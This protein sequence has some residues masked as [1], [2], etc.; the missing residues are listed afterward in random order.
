M[1]YKYFYTTQ[2]SKCFACEIIAA[3]VSKERYVL[4][5]MFINSY[6]TL[7]NK[8]AFQVLFIFSRHS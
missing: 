4:I 1:M 3:F 2:Q 5:L 7:L 8:S 6:V